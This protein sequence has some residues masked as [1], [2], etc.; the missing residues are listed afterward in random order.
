MLRQ[1]AGVSVKPRQLRASFVTNLILEDG[2]AGC[3]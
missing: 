2:V 3:F 1:K